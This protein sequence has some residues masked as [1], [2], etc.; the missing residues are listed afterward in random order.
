MPDWSGTCLGMNTD[1]RRTL[2]C[3]ADLGQNPGRTIFAHHFRRALMSATTT[4]L[5]SR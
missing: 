1:M 4:S 3:L 2:I 5:A